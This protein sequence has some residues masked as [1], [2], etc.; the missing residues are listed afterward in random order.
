[1]CRVNMMKRGPTARRTCWSSVAL[2]VINVSSF[3]NIV[4]PFGSL[5]LPSLLRPH[6]IVRDVRFIM[7]AA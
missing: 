2:K 1:V 6:C 3:A 7:L 5:A 4:R